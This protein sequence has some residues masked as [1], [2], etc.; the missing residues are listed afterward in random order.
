MSLGFNEASYKVIIRP[1]IS[2]KATLAADKNKQFVF[3]ILPDATKPQ[4]K[5]AIEHLFNVKVKSVRVV[6]VLG[7]KRNFRQMEGRKNHFKKAYVAL[8]DGYDID[9]TGA[10]KS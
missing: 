4:V 2:E 8:K 5:R 10:Q 7:K 9:F 3:E 1:R 6:N